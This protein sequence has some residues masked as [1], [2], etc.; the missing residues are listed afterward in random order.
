M[1]VLIF[2]LPYFR[3]FSKYI[4]HL[5]AQFFFEF[6]ILRMCFRLNIYICISTQKHVQPLFTNLKPWHIRCDAG[7]SSS[8]FM[9][10]MFWHWAI[11]TFFKI[12][13]F[14]IQ[15]LNKFIVISDENI[16]GKVFLDENFKNTDLCT[17]QQNDL[18]PL[19]S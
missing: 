9:L 3:I 8:I 12:N 2:L 13:W 10:H 16:F 17:N 11:V 14:V 6:L 15:K 18:C 19:S 1:R 5:W 7:P 4:M